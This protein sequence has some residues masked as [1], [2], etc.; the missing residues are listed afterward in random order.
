MPPLN[1]ILETNIAGSTK[2][3]AHVCEAANSYACVQV[4]D[5]CFVNLILVAAWLEVFK[6]TVNISESVKTDTANLRNC[7]CLC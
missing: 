4:Q 3:K 1:Y 2:L 7:G 6:F 5:V